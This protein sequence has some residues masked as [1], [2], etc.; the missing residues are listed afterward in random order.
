[1]SLG[2]IVRVTL[3][4]PPLDP[5]LGSHRGPSPCP[6]SYQPS[7]RHLPSISRRPRSS[8]PPS[9]FSPG[10][11][12]HPR[13]PRH[14]QHH[15]YS[16]PWQECWRAIA[17]FHLAYQGHWP[18]RHRPQW[19]FPSS[20]S[21]QRCCSVWQPKRSTN[22]FLVGRIPSDLSPTAARHLRTLLHIVLTNSE[23]RKLFSDFSVI[24]RDLLSKSAA[25]ASQ[26]IAP[27]Q[28]EL[29]QADQAAPDHPLTTQHDP[30][31]ATRSHPPDSPPE[32]APR[33]LD[34]ILEHARA[35][36]RQAGKDAT[37]QD[38]QTSEAPEHAKK[39]GLMGKMKDITVRSIHV[40]SRSP[41]SPSNSKTSPTAFLLST[42]I[43]STN[44]FPA[45]ANSSPKNTFQKRDASNLSFGAKKSSWSA[46]NIKIT[47]PL[48]VG[49][50]T[51]SRTTPSRAVR[52][53][54]IS[55]PEMRW[56]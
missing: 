22:V 1:M 31:S 41:S 52:S 40:S 27:S 14:H 3:P 51:I 37:R 24:G 12:A 53:R 8:W 29:R 38:I 46:S 33:P 11:Q 9:A 13:P 4:S 10:P 32:P 23:A 43:V 56:R 44:P 49:S 48:S 26:A 35:R 25:K 39:T 47:K 7:T 15:S 16:P 54:T 2:S 55:C 5:P 28:D 6:S 18:R 19:S 21:R 34:D 30:D 50:W 20:P 42:R 45:D 17:K 36:A